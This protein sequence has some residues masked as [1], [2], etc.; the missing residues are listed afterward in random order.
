MYFSLTL[1]FVKSFYDMYN[2]ST[3]NCCTLCGYSVAKRQAQCTMSS[4]VENTARLSVADGELL[5]DS[6][7]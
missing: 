6:S 4:T 7:K 5:T 1:L 2:N 3:T